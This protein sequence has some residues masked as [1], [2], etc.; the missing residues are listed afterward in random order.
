MFKNFMTLTNS[1][2]T[3]D[4]FEIA[5]NY[6]GNLIHSTSSN[7]TFLRLSLLN[8]TFMSSYDGIYYFGGSNSFLYF[9]ELKIFDSMLNFFIFVEGKNFSLIFDFVSIMNCSETISSHYIVFVYLNNAQ[10]FDFISNSNWLF[11]YGLETSCNFINFNKYFIFFLIGIYHL[12]I[13]NCQ[14]FN[15]TIGETIISNSNLFYFAE[16]VSCNNVHK[17]VKMSNLTISNSLLYSYIDQYVLKNIS[18]TAIT[19][20]IRLINVRSVA[21]FSCTAIS[22]IENYD[23]SLNPLP[24]YSVSANINISNCII[25]NFLF[26][27]DL[28]LVNPKNL[29]IFQSIGSMLVKETNFPSNSYI[30]NFYNISLTNTLPNL[31]VFLFSGNSTLLTVLFSS[32]IS[33]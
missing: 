21:I 10:Y 29:I 6:I 32:I 7:I 5:N 28:I 31:T 13:F 22:N 16:F 17:F 11:Q 12:Y 24:W 27:Y 8:V 23:T 18:S 30:F 15:F 33:F 2:A 19:D 3:F 9:K 1:D 4:N 25:N 20:D 14:F 26:M